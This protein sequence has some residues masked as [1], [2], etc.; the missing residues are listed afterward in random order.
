[1]SKQIINYVYC[2]TNKLYCNN[3][4]MSKTKSISFSNS[5][6]QKVLPCKENHILK[7][8]NAGGQAH[9]SMY[10][11]VT[12]AYQRTEFLEFAYF[13]WYFIYSVIVD[14]E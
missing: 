5:F 7:V 1:M 6:T 14:R 13:V 10:V 11:T 4:K 8:Y 12:M 2:N 3:I 9:T